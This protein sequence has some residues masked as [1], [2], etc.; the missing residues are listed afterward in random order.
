MNDSAGLSS[1]EGITTN[2]KCHPNLKTRDKLAKILDQV[3]SQANFDGQGE[4]NL[5]TIEG[6]E[7]N[8]ADME[9]GIVKRRGRQD[10]D[11]QD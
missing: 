11:E 5:L 10:K 7:L 6:Q 3:N 2:K 9:N 4:T 8:I 1:R